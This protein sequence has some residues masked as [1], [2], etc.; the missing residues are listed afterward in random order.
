MNNTI[1][2]V[3]CTFSLAPVKFHHQFSCLSRISSGLPEAFVNYFSSAHTNFPNV[4]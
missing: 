3:A 1:T 4:S 2:T